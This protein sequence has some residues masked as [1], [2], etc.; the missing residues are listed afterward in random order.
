MA[1]QISIN[2]LVQTVGQLSTR[3]FE[4]FFVKIQSLY[5]QKAASE[6]IVEENKLVNQI[7]TTLSPSK[8]NRF[9]EK[10]PIAFLKA[11]V[12]ATFL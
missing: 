11:L 7:K 6:Q 9:E 2:E 3:D 1:S 5:A 8:Q 10:K 12:T 4:E